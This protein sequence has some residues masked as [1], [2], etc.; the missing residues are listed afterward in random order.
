VS[1]ATDRVPEGSEHEAQEFRELIRFTLAGWLG[2]LAAGVALDGLGLHR[3]A[4]G[5]WL[6][7]TLSGE[8][9]SLLEGAYAFRQRVR[10]RSASL[11]EAYGWGKLLGVVF[12]WFIDWG[13]RAA[14]VAVNGVGGFYIPFF[15]AMTDQIGGN[16]SGLVYFRRK[17]GSW[18]AGLA[19]YLRHPVMITGLVVVLAVPGALFLARAAGFSPST[20]VRTAFETIAANLCWLPPAV[21]WWSA[22]RRRSRPFDSEGSAL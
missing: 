14:G 20:Q 3:S 4:I 9:E 16:L 18:R 12:P 11:A 5:Q 7:R 19:A 15:Y 10:G 8:G 22:R 1:D 2:G 6:V 17:R 13:S 21:G